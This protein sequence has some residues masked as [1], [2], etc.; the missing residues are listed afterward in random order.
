MSGWENP[1][2]SFTL[3]QH[4]NTAHG[5]FCRDFSVLLSTGILLCSGPVAERVTS[6]EGSCRT[7]ASR[8]SDSSGSSSSALHFHAFILPP[9]GRKE[10]QRRCKNQNLQKVAQLHPPALH[11]SEMYGGITQA[12]SQHNTTQHNPTQH[13]SKSQHNRKITTQQQY[14]NTTGVLSCTFV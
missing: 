2:P 14:K 6:N 7:S 3:P 12:A 5:T 11:S 8:Y 9:Y 13:N 4:T 10:K 1:T